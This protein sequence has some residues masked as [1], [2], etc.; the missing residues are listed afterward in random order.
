MAEPKLITRRGRRVLV[1]GCCDRPHGYDRGGVLCMESPHGKR[2]PHPVE[3]TPERLRQL[4]DEL[5][6]SPSKVFRV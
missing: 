6:Q 4:A 3:F 1:T 5:E 2:D